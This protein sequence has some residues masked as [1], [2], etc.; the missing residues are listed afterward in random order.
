MTSPAANPATPDR[1]QRRVVGDA[2]PDAGM[3]AGAAASV[4][5]ALVVDDNE[6]V[7][8]IVSRQLRQL[9]VS[10]VVVACDGAEAVN[11]LQTRPPFDLLVCDLR[12]PHMDGVELLRHVESLQPTMAVILMSG[13]S[14]KVLATSEEVARARHLVVLGALQ[15][16][17]RTCDLKQLLERLDGGCEPRACEVRLE[18]VAVDPLRDAIASGAIDVYMQPQVDTQTGM[19]VGVEALTRWI[20]PD[21]SV[22]LPEQFVGVAESC[23]LIHTLTERILHQSLCAASQ[24]RKRGLETRISINL[25]T[26][27]LGRLDLPEMLSELLTYYDIRPDNLQLEITESRAMQDFAVAL[28]VLT[29]LRL[30]GMRLSIDDFGTGYSSLSQLR[31][32]PFNELKIDRGFVNDVAEPESRRIVASSVTLAHTLGMVAVA[33]GVETAAV[34]NAVCAM[35]C[36]IVQGYFISRPMPKADLL[37]WA[38]RRVA[39]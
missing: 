8:N 27:S 37:R 9:G 21:R 3:V 31:R 23:G 14:A 12:M 30:R 18:N 2:A 5:S 36:D 26:L 24:W 11:H 17:V 19:L 33:E 32:V 20:L 38:T 10:R 1:V 39:R 13:T 25:S 7:R 16:P 34:W 15:K 28:D 35:G 29:R 4:S 22:V 6:F